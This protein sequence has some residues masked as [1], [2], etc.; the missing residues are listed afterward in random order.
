[1][2][3]SF[4]RSTVQIFTSQHHYEEVLVL[5]D[6]KSKDRLIELI[7]QAKRSIRILV[8]R[9]DYQCFIDALVEAK[10]RG[11]SVKIVLADYRK[12][13][14][15]FYDEH[16]E[17]NFRKLKTNQEAFR[18][19][20]DTGVKIVMS[21]F[22]AHFAFHPKLIVIDENIALVGTANLNKNGFYNARNFFLI[23]NE[24]SVVNDSLKLFARDFRAQTRNSRF[25]WSQDRKLAVAPYDYYDKL[26]ELISS[27]RKDVCVYQTILAHPA[28]CDKLVRIAEQ[29]V[30]VRVLTSKRNVSRSETLRSFMSICESKLKN[31]KNIKIK[32]LN[33]PHYVHAKVVIVDGGSCS[34]GSC[35]IGSSLFCNEAFHMSREVGVVSKQAETIHVIRKTFEEDFLKAVDDYYGTENLE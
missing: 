19:L 31:K 12:S 10:K 24:P 33:E 30:K 16:Y 9:I 14:K 32:Y 15:F 17:E 5:P 6:K 4:A 18:R 8:Y 21:D 28:I 34:G 35:F 2:V 1:M 13:E 22:N 29:G 25:S 20:R 23:T 26:F 11:V 7:A 3:L 27:A